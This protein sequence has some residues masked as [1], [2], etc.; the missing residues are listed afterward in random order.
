M[1]KLL[2]P[3]GYAPVAAVIIGYA[4]GEVGEAAPRRT[5]DVTRL[6]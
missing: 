1:K 5:D 2:I 4:D 6:A 3:E